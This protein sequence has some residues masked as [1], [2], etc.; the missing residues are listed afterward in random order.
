MTRT[1]ERCKEKRKTVYIFHDEWRGDATITS[2]NDGGRGEELFINL[3]SY[4][5]R[6]NLSEY[7]FC[8]F[9]DFLN[10]IREELCRI[11]KQIQ[12]NAR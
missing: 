2:E 11:E 7:E 5:I 1:A 4:G 3:E 10:E 8:Y 9:C 12:K 6:A